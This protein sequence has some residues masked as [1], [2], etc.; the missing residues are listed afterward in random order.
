MEGLKRMHRRSWIAAAGAA[1]AAAVLPARIR[2]QGF[3]AT[4]RVGAAPANT[5]A[6]AYYAQDL[7]IFKKAGLTVEISSFNNGPGIAAA[8]ASGGLDVGISTPISLAEAVTRSVPFPIVA[9]GAMNTQQATAMKLLVSADAPFHDAKDFEGKTIAL[10][11][12]KTV[13]ELGIDVWLAHGGVDPANVRLIE[14]P[15]TAMGPAVER[16]TVAAALIAEPSLSIAMSDG[17]VRELANPFGLIA[18]QFLLSAWFSTVALVQKDPAR[19]KAFAAAIHETG[20]WANGHHDEYMAILAKY[21]QGDLE[22][23]RR[24][25]HTT[26]A[27]S[28][29]LSDLQPQLDVAYKYGMLPRPVSASEMVAHYPAT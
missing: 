1:L 2:A 22:T 27:E 4:L 28:L 15:L 18:P 17:K 26:Y 5:Y 12:L 11:A 8:V 29:R 25:I 21:S 20:T 16:G 6:E 13:S 19:L 24:T 14:M 7:G 23:L 9:G 3:A 10:T